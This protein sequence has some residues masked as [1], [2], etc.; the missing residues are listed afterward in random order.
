M[1]TR[2]VPPNANDCSVPHQPPA[3]CRFRRLVLGTLGA[4]VFVILFGSVVRITGSGA[5]CGQHWPTCRGEITHLPNTLATLIEYTHRLTSGLLGFLVFGLAVVAFR[6]FPRRHP[7]RLWV[8]VSVLFMIVEA[9]IGMLLV[10]FGLVANDTS[11]ARAVV[12][13]LHLISTLL[14]LSAMTLTAVFSLPACAVCPRDTRGTMLVGVGLLGF[15]VVSASGAVTALGD[16]VFP[17]RAG[18]TVARLA[19]EHSQ[20]AQFLEH[21]RAFHPMLALVLIVSLLVI[22]PRVAERGSR[23]AERLTQISL[24][25]CLFQGVIGALNVLLRAPA[26]LQVV[27]LFLS[28]S[29]WIALVSLGSELWSPRMLG[30]TTPP[31]VARL[32]RPLGDAGTGPANTWG[33]SSGRLHGP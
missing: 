31:R 11:V 9:L 27:H 17:V 30:Q 24:A 8:C 3:W 32:L 33:R 29:I 26:G 13:P 2:D 1:H 12:M 5:G 14:L 10:R 16:T 21:G 4:T 6:V 22:L 28:C 25:L 19:A 18:Q 20:P 23:T 15:L 7:V